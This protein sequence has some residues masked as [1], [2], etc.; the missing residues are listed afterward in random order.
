MSA[1]LISTQADYYV[2]LLRLLADYPDGSAPVLDAIADFR[3]RYE[4]QISADHFTPVDSNPNQEKW[5]NHVRWARAKL[6]KLGYLEMPHHGVWKITNTGRGLA[7]R[8]SRSV[9]PRCKTPRSKNWAH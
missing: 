7:G 9:A 4:H 3:R 1:I 2:P 5:D 6:K 8:K